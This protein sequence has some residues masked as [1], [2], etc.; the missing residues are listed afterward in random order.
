VGDSDLSVLQHDCVAKTTAN[1][2]IC[3]IAGLLLILKGKLQRRIFK[4]CAQSDPRQ[5]TSPFPQ[6]ATA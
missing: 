4:R 3:T 5:P 1:N 2:Q 6:T